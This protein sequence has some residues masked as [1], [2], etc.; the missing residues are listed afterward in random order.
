ALLAPEKLVED[1]RGRRHHLAD[2][3]G[4]HRE[5]RARASGGEAAEEDGEDQATEAADDRQERH[6]NP[7][8]AA[9]GE[10]ER[11]GGDESPEAEVDG[12][13]EGEHAPLAEEHVVAQR[14]DDRDP[15]L[16][17]DRDGRWRP[18]R[19]R[20]HDEERGGKQPHRGPAQPSRPAGGRHVEGTGGRR[21]AHVSRVPKRPVGR[22]MRMSTSSRYGMMGAPC[23]AVTRKGWCSG[24]AMSTRTPIDA[25]ALPTEMLSATANV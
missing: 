20:Q 7:E 19:D 16:V 4:D 13:P 12:V 5:D 15:H 24:P 1:Q 25:S 8:R 21:K 3:E 23:A 10:V 6:G 11:V 18:H 17:H 2:A 22:T 14:E 9:P